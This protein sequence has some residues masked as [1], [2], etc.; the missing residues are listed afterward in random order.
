[1]TD[2]L[3]CTI[4]SLIDYLYAKCFSFLS[5][6]A[7]LLPFDAVPLFLRCFVWRMTALMSVARLPGLC[8]CLHLKQPVMSI[9]TP[10]R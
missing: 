8:A 9:S 2:V 3:I 1:M 10:P 6:C 5:F 7:I 4:S